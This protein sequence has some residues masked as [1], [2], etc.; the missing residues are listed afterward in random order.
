MQYLRMNIC[1][2][3]LFKFVFTQG[4]MCI[5][6]LN[7]SLIPSSPDMYCLQGGEEGAA[8]QILQDITIQ[9]K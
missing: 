2:S 1:I 8:E 9:P 5:I 6:N 4:S 3:G 7:Q